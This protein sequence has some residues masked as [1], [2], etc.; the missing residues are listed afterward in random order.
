MNKK[1]LLIL[2]LLLSLVLLGSVFVTSASSSITVNA[3]L[4][5]SSID[6]ANEVNEIIIP[7]ETLSLNLN[8]IDTTNEPVTVTFKVTTEKTDTI[9]TETHKYESE[10]N[11]Q[12]DISH[13][14]IRADTLGKNSF[15][16]AGE[17]TK[18]T[19]SVKTTHPD[20]SSDLISR[21]LTISRN[22]D[23]TSCG[24]ILSTNND[25]SSGTYTIN[26]SGDPI[27]VYCDMTT[28]GGGWTKINRSIAR[29]MI[30]KN[31]GGL[32]AKQNTFQSGF[33]G[34]KPYFISRSTNPGGGMEYDINTGFSFNEMYL[35]NIG[36]KSTSYKTSSDDS[37]EYE[38]DKYVMSVWEYTGGGPNN[39]RGDIG[40]GVPADS[41]PTTTY[42]GDGGSFFSNSG[43][44]DY[45][46][47]FETNNG[48]IFTTG[49][50]DTTLRIAA[51]ESGGQDEGWRWER[52]SIYV[53]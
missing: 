47:N 9:Y 19:V 32:E 48:K 36:F 17:S 25:A 39:Y 43:V 28:D 18:A 26:P 40:F 8:N 16:V 41:G 7:F 29:T 31:G 35:K 52:G 10:S 14:A 27:E 33:D 38:E 46:F 50:A 11:K 12:I 53:R 21:E 42:T 15:P 34:N 4:Q 6:V 5:A 13:V 24:S 22:I 1:A 23:N 2:P 49:T 45:P 37:S 30:N 20:V 44:T 51:S 3:N